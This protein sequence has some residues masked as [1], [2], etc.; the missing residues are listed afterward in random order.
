MKLPAGRAYRQHIPLITGENVINFSPWGD[1]GVPVSGEA[2]ICLQFF[3]MGCRKCGGRLLAIHSDNPDILLRAAR[4]ALL[5][6][7]QGISMAQATGNT[8]L[9]DASPSAQTLIIE[10]LLSMNLNRF[11]AL[12]ERQPYSVTAYHLTNSGQSSPLD[13]RN[14]PLKIYHLPMRIIR[15]L[16]KANNPDHLNTWNMLVARGKERPKS[17]KNKQVVQQKEKGNKGTQE[18]APRRERNYFYEDLFRLPQGIS[19]LRDKVLL[20]RSKSAWTSNGCIENA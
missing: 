18:L 19:S 10:T 12:D 9:P 14:P 3:P 8:K 17:S 7:V 6:N 13:E 16:A 20:I 11:D 15:F 5:E 2:L 4:E 1:P